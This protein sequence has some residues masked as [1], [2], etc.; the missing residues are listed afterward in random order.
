M[1]HH[2]AELATMDT[3]SR[4]IEHRTCVLF[5]IGNVDPF[6]N[7]TLPGRWGQ[8]GG[9]QEQFVFPVTTTTLKLV[10]LRLLLGFILGVVFYVI[11]DRMLV[12][13]CFLSQPHNL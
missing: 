2:I 10:S 4:R 9:H 6:C 3:F 1:S 5:G 11:E 13:K 7:V 8:S 12:E